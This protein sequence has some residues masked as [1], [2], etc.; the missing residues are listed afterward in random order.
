MS[1]PQGLRPPGRIQDY[2]LGMK[3]AIHCPILA[4]GGL[5]STQLLS[6]LLPPNLAGPLVGE[7]MAL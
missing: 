4:L 7:T 6:R 3:Q 1:L 2:H 5:V